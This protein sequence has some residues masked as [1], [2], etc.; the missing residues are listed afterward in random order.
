[1]NSK[2]SPTILV[3]GAQGM[4]GHTIYNYLSRYYTVFGTTKHITTDPSLIHFDYRKHTLEYIYKK[5]GAI[6]Y[7]INCIGILPSETDLT[8]MHAINAVFPKRIAHFAEKNE[9][10]FIHISTDAVFAP[11]E[12][13]VYE[14]SQ[15]TPIDYYGI[16]KL[17]GEPDSRL[18]ITIRTSFLGLDPRNHKGLLEYISKEKVLEGYT[19]QNWSGCTSLQFA[20]LCN[21]IIVSDRFDSLRLLSPVYHFTPIRNVSKH[22]II[23]SYLAVVGSKKRVSKRV[24]KFISRSLSSIYDKELHLQNYSSDLFKSLQQL[25]EFENT[26]K[27]ARKKKLAFVLGTRA[28]LIRAVLILEHLQK[29]KDIE[30]ILIWSGQH[31]SDNLKGVFFR[32][33]KVKKPDIELDCKGDTD[34]EVASKVIANLY[35]VLEKIKP[36]AVAFLGD[37]NTVIGCIAANQLNIPFLHI[38]GCWHSYDWRMP[39]EKYRTLADHMADVIYT[40]AQEY[41]DRGIA[42]GL[43]PK[44]IVVSGNPAVDILNRFYFSKK[45]SF[46]ELATDDFFTK[47]GIK[48]NEYY[49]MTCHRRENVHLPKAFSN[50]LN[51]IEYAKDPVYFAASYRTQAVMKNLKKKLPRNLIVVDPV[52]YEEILVLMTNAKAVIT[53]SGTVNEEACILGVPC[54]NIRKATER[55]QV[56]D[57]K[58][59]VKFDPDQPETYTP[60]IIFKKLTKITGTTWRQP[61]GNGTG[62]KVIAEDIIKRLRENN[63]RGHLPYD[64]HLP[65]K[66]PF[67]EDGIKV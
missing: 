29:A 61:L 43:N 13:A 27:M 33:F 62:T 35:P 66:R 11:D 24:G 21:D 52:G 30:L 12:T 19:N 50:I 55:P 17:A 25:V 53:D 23:K 26:E 15:T 42:E 40:Y 44:Y 20:Q 47:R 41:K 58:S 60:E 67:M 22:D 34:A 59:A 65:I 49:F 56:Y 64:N 1:M 57:V 7:I 51:L 54:I 4:V 39:E 9:A 28:E 2:K 5:C 38:E 46:D 10:K 48:K 8:V 31:Y 63:L 36:D 32:E 37:T 3:F 45:A 14:N 18:G 6:D 16:T